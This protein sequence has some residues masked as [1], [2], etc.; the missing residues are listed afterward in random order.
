MAARRRA[1]SV[2][3][4]PARNVNATGSVKGSEREIVIAVNIRIVNGMQIR[5][6]TMNESGSETLGAQSITD[7]MTT[8]AVAAVRLATMPETGI[9]SLEKIKTIIPK[10][11][12]GIMVIGLQG[13]IGTTTET[14][15]DGIKRALGSN[16]T[17]MEGKI[18]R[19]HLVILC[20]MV[21]RTARTESEVLLST[22][23]MHERR[24]IELHLKRKG[25]KSEQRR[26]D[27]SRVLAFPLKTYGSPLACSI[28][29]GGQR[30]REAKGE[31]CSRGDPRGG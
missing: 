29:R 12:I 11:R 18:G 4:L 21:H 19:V 22:R 27:D 13:T 9:A 31:S 5:I 14:S 25:R 2:K 20:K 17:R 8:R 10:T 23:T 16:T 24:E 28:R 1:G 30:A 6:V 15:G 26:Y 7:T 3:N